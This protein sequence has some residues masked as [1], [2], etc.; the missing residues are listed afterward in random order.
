[1][2][3]SKEQNIKLNSASCYLN[4]TRRR[5]NTISVGVVWN[6][7]D[8]VRGPTLWVIIY[9]NNIYTCEGRIVMGYSE[10]WMEITS[11]S[12]L[13]S[14]ISTELP[15]HFCRRAELGHPPILLLYS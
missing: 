2:H 13:A 11:S 10:S 8:V 4:R 7:F 1:M 14:E 6:R 9:L 15:V 3:Q 5:D 12:R